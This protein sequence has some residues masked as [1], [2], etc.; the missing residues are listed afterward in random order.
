MLLFTA[1]A[2]VSAPYPPEGLS[3]EWVQ[4][5]GR[6]LQLKMYG[7]EFYA[8]TE[9]AEGYTVLFSA[10]DNTY[11]YAEPETN[12]RSLRRSRTRAT[13]PPPAGLVKHLKEPREVVSAIRA[14]N[15]QRY[16]PDR[17]AKWKSRKEAV[18]QQRSNARSTKPGVDVVTGA[19][20]PVPTQ[21][22]FAKAQ[23]VS[24]ARVGLVILVQFPD[25]PA[26]GSVDPTNFP[27]TQVAMERYSNEIGY[28]DNGNT[29]SIRDYYADQS[30]GALDFTQVVSPIVTL[31]HPRNYYNFSDYPANTSYSLMGIAGR[32][33]VAD[34]VAELKASGFDFSGLSVDA[35]NRVLATSLMFAGNLSGVWAQGLWP[36]AWTMGSYV[37]VGIPGEPRYIYA[38]QITNVP[39]AAPVI[40]T[41]CHELGH[42]LLAYPDFYDTD[43]SDGASEGVGEH[44]L[45][46]SGNYLNGGRTPA[47]IDLYL[48]DFSGWATI[49]DLALNV[50]TQQS[51]TAGGHGYRLRKPGNNT[52]YFL[53]ENRSDDDRW[54][55]HA[56]DKGIVI[57]HVDEAVTTDNMR[58]QMTA[59]QHYELSLEQADGLFDLE[60]NRDRGDAQDLFDSFAVFSDSTTPNANWWDG[61]TSG[62]SLQVLNPAG[63]PTMHL[64]FFSDV[65][66]VPVG[67]A[68]DATGLPWSDDG[69]TFTPGSWFGELSATAQ[70][71]IDQATHY[72]VGDSEEASLSTAV[73]GPGSLTYWWKVS[74]EL[75]GDFLRF[76]RNDVEHPAA[77]AISGDSGWQQRTIPIPAGLHTLRWTYGKNASVAAGADAAWLDRVIFT[78]GAVDSDGDGLSD[79]EEALLGTDPNSVDSDGDG[80]VDGAGGVVLLSNYPVGID[81]DGDGFIDGEADLGTDPSGSNIGDLA[82]RGSPNNIIDTGD[83]VVLMR[84]LNGLS[85]PTELEA[86]LADIDGDGDLDVGDLVLLKSQ[87]TQ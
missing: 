29:G 68:V 3:S 54:A 42:L 12:G 67:E 31:P 47:P 73:T 80:L 8:R 44:S 37:D 55:T 49:S 26:T 52:E 23:A 24:G 20:K 2:A 53:I 87:L 15:I 34:A 1:D 7:D 45:M 46:G 57:W 40:G 60:A 5:D 56:P 82:P 38:Y 76:Y 43:S 11:Y 18:L 50:A 28:T 10:T 36:H 75:N 65:F 69:L 58:Q 74:S 14:S 83:Q 39:N 32:M 6:V 84:F 77:P 30:S 48:K 81:V 70:D 63:T 59:S 25:D 78:P 79:D 41:M 16:A 71:G 86:I 62:V 19:E 33:L 17:A 21:E 13:S 22:L 72:P 35:Y 85:Q 9:T 27:T 66:Q 61:S 51:L 64:Q 4:P